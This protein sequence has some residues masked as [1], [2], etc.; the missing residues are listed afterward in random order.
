MDRSLVSLAT[1]SLLTAAGTVLVLVLSEGDPTGRALLA[2]AVFATAGVLIG[3]G[4]GRLDLAE[5]IPGT[6]SEY[7]LATFSFMTAAVVFLAGVGGKQSIVLFGVFM[8]VAAIIGGIGV[9]RRAAV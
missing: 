6:Q 3:Y 7:A 4:A 5:P 1:G 2:A 8:T 9:T